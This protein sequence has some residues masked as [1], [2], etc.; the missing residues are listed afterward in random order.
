MAKAKTLQ[1][2]KKSSEGKQKRK[3]KKGAKVKWHQPSRNLLNEKVIAKAIWECLKENDPDGVMEIL[4][5]HLEA[6]NKY[7]ISR[8][9]KMPRSTIY[10][11]LKGGN[12][13][14]KTIAKLVSST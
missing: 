14:L 6:K 3:L 11:A 9:S 5:A 10:N 8:K 1:R 7:E 2:Q 4:S 12:P 13:T